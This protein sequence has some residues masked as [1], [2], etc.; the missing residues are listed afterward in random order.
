MTWSSA[1]SAVTLGNIPSTCYVGLALASHNNTALAAAQFDHV[2][3]IDS[4]LA[5]PTGL[6]V[7]AT[8]GNVSLSWQAAQA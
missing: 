1:G 8:N 5:A 3:L 7:S 2:T 6:A 4:S